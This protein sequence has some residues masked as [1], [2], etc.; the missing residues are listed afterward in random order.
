M[1]LVVDAN[2]FVSELLRARGRRLVE[3]PRLR[4]W[5]SAKAWEEAR[6]EL[7]KRAGKIVSQGRLTRTQAEALLASALRIAEERAVAI[8]SEAFGAFEEPAAYR[9]PRDPDDIP[10]VALALAL[11]GAEGRCGI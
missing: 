7:P 6:H 4:L 10:T 3:E 2:I 11:G 1:L 5:V 8:P 9:I